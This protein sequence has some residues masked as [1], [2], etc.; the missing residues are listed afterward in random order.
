LDRL[1]YTAMTGAKYLFDRQATLSH[2]LANAST[3]GFRADMVGMRAVP[4]TG[5]QGGTR[6]FAVETTIG[7]DFATGQM[8]TTGRSLDAAIQG[9]GWFAAQGADGNEAYT[10]DGSFQVGPDATLQLSNGMQVAGTGGPITM[11]ADAQSVTIGSD[12]TVTVKSA[13]STL[14]TTIGKLKLV[15]PPISSLAKGVDGM[16]HLKSGDAAD[17]DAAVKVVGGSL[18]GSNVNVIESMVDMIG[19]ARQYELQMKM[20][21][22]AEQNEQKAGT[23]LG[24]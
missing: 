10:R 3:T 11:P 1:I 8:T 22:T 18:E 15:N 4:T 5:P 17:A 23:L 7:S 13:S 12:G 24:G 20:L 9:Q 21:T 6:V 16:F 19:A 2:N 14:P